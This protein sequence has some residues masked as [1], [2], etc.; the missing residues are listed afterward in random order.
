MVGAPEIRY[1]TKVNVHVYTVQN[2][3][4]FDYLLLQRRGVAKGKLKSKTHSD[5]SL[6]PKIRLVKCGKIRAQQLRPNLHINV[7]TAEHK[8]LTVSHRYSCLILTIQQ[9]TNAN[10]IHH[11]NAECKVN[12]DLRLTTLYISL[13]FRSKQPGCTCI[14]LQ[15][16]LLLVT[17]CS[18]T[19]VGLV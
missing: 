8:V 14:S 18:N 11:L 15:D 2:L 1:L 12:L 16:Y 10:N 3:A 9:P 13:R 7:N 19:T 5:Y 4:L 6:P 17:Y